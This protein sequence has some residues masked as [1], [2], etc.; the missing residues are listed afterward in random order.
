[1]ERSKYS[2]VANVYSQN[3]ANGRGSSNG[4][5]RSRERDGKSSLNTSA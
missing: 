1:M 3:V 5:S 2:E 4:N